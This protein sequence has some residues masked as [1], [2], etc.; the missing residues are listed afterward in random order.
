MHRF[1][2]CAIKIDPMKYLAPMITAMLASGLSFAQESSTIYSFDTAEVTVLDSTLE[3]E[4]H[5]YFEYFFSINKKGYRID[6]TFEKIE[7]DACTEEK[8]EQLKKEVIELVKTAPKM[9]RRMK[10]V[11][12]NTR[13]P[14]GY[15]IHII[16]A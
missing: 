1:T 9:K 8:K 15:K 4:I 14:G 13:I 16:G 10:K 7:C 11:Y 6:I 5:A 12:K 3:G 2:L